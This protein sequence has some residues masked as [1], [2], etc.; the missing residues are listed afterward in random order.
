NYP[1]PFIDVGD[2]SVWASEFQAQA[3]YNSSCPGNPDGC[4]PCGEL[5]PPHADGSGDGY[6]TN[7]ADFTF[8][9]INWLLRHEDCCDDAA[10]A[11]GPATPGWA[12]N[13]KS[14]LSK[15]LKLPIL[16]MNVA[17]LAAQGHAELAPAD[18]NGDGW[19]DIVDMLMVAMHQMAGTGLP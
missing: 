8:I 14:A 10:P 16:Q 19:I 11:Q 12:L 15:K 5:G 18:L 1:S 13:K 17:V 2:F 6:V 4:T 7:T 9:Q 3:T